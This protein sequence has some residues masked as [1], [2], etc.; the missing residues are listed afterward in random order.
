MH[1]WLGNGQ[2]ILAVHE[3]HDC[4][5]VFELRG[6]KALEC[7]VVAPVPQRNTFLCAFNAPAESQNRFLESSRGTRSVQ[8]VHE[9]SRA[10]CGVSISP[11]VAGFKPV[12][13]S[14]AERKRA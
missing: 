7:A 8:L 4:C 1:D 11:S 10:T 9:G 5:F 6:D 2:A 3:H 12:P 14:T 13:V